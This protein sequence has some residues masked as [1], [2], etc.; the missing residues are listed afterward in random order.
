MIR[1]FD[2]VRIPRDE[3]VSLDRAAD[4]G[5]STAQKVRWIL[6]FSPQEYACGSNGIAN[7]CV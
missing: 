3:I 4:G 5:S 7:V 2:T 6:F 1:S